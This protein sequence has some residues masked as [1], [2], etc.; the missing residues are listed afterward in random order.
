MLSVESTTNGISVVTTQA[1]QKDFHHAPHTHACVSLLV[2][3]YTIN[4]GSGPVGFSN[5]GVFIKQPHVFKYS[6]R[7][8]T[9]KDSPPRLIF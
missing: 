3:L 9:C 2:V 6:Q 8:E 7:T 4:L 1:G 5:L